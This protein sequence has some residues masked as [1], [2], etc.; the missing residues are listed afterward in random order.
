[1]PISSPSPASFAARLI[2]L[3]CMLSWFYGFPVAGVAKTQSVS[4]GKNVSERQR[5]RTSANRGSSG[6]SSF[7]YSVFTSSTLPPIR[8]L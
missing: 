6:T 2:C 7:D 8:L 3:F 5:S 1:M 4:R